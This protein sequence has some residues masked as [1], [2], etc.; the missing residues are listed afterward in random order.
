MCCLSYICYEALGQ[1]V[2]NISVCVAWSKRPGP[3]HRSLTDLLEDS[4]RSGP[5][6]PV[7]ETLQR[8]SGLCWLYLN[9]REAGN[10]SSP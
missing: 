7:V 10:L 3:D 6:V 2:I 4:V 8:K 5:S 1:H 9:L